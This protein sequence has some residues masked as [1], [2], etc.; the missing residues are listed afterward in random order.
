MEKIPV[1]NQVIKDKRK[2]LKITQE[3]FT[4]IINKGISTV[5]RYDTGDIIPENTLILICDKLNLNFYDLLKKQELENKRLQLKNYE[6]LINKNEGNLLFYGL[7][8]MIDEKKEKE[9]EKRNN[10]TYSFNQLYSILYDEFYWNLG[11]INKKESLK[12]KKYFT[13][14]DL[15]EEKILVKEI[16]TF[17]ND[18]KEEKYIDIFS[19]D[20]Y[21]SFLKELKDYFNVKLAIM[22]K[23]KLK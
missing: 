13:E 12:N 20:N 17:I 8:E 11:K 21:E 19:I 22:R 10:L 7:K 4:K 3:D 5:R 2:E 14:I 18:E 1:I 23:E 9:E 6:K 15:K 16:K